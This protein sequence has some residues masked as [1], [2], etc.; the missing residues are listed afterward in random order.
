MWARDG[1]ELFY[2]SGDALMVVPI[3]TGPA[4][5]AGSPAIVFEEPYVLGFGGRAYDKMMMT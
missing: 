5:V 2:R 4:F 1:R 3:Q